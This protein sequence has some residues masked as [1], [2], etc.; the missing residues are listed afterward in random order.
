[1]ENER[2][3]LQFYIYSLVVIGFGIL[4]LYI[5]K[6]GTNL[7]LGTIGIQLIATIYIFIQ[8][9]KTNMYTQYEQYFGFIFP[10]IGVVVLIWYN[11]I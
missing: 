9:K 3:G 11:T 6:Q 4:G 7:L 1:M 10:F 5:Y 2:L 8:G